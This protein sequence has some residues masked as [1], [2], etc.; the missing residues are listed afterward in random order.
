MIQA[1]RGLYV[2][3]GREGIWEKLSL[4]GDAVHG[5]SIRFGY[6]DAPHAL[7]LAGDY[8][9]IAELYRRQNAKTAGTAT[10]FANEL[11]LFY[12]A[13]P[14]VLWITFARDHLWWCFAD[15]EVVDLA[16]P[17]RERAESVGTRLKRVRGRWLSADARG[18]PLRIVDLRGS[19]TALQGYRGTICALK[20]A[21]LAYLLLRINGRDSAEA[22]AVRAARDNL[23]STLVPL[24][25]GL[26][27]RDFELLVELIFSHAG[28][29]RV[30]LTGGPQKAI[31]LELELPLT[32]ER[33]V[34]QVKSR[35]DQREVNACIEKLAEDPS[36]TRA[37]IVYHSAEEAVSAGTSGIV[38]IGP[39]ALAGRV[40]EAG[41]VGWVIGKVG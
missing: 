6:R 4:D 18:Q 31:D 11:R 21:D 29:R 22:S 30:S 3:L 33:A 9:A 24:I 14:E 36:A 40:V 37:F 26:H 20:P 5:P 23:V 32:N 39:A 27:W 16:P 2:K 17:D 35:T 38:L 34:V 41:L 10:R 7:A 12:E 25:K 1:S 13:G 8:G 28:W 19:L 15:R